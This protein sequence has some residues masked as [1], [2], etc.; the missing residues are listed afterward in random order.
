MQIDVVECIAFLIGRVDHLQSID[1]P[2]I[3]HR[4]R[5]ALHLRLTALLLGHD[6]VLG[7]EHTDDIHVHLRYVL[8]DQ[9]LVATKLG[10][11]IST[12]RLQIV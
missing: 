2:G 9:V 7:I 11:M 12:N 3:A 1:K 8:V 5:V 10:C 6:D 4:I